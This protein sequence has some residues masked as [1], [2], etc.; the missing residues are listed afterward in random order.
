MLQLKSTHRVL[1]WL[2]RMIICCL[3]FDSWPR[4]SCYRLLRWNSV[5]YVSYNIVDQ[6]DNVPRRVPGY[7]FDDEQFLEDMHLPRRQ[8][9]LRQFLHV[10]ALCHTVVPQK[11]SSGEIQLQA[12]SPGMCAPD[13]CVCVRVNSCAC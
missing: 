6:K 11:R 1:L 5:F 3:H 8:E 10:C 2:S 7:D 13:V 12:S 4:F 9:L